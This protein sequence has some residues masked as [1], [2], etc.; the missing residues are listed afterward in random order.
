MPLLLVFPFSLDTFTD[1]AWCYMYLYT[2]RCRAEIIF[3]KLSAF[4]KRHEGEIRRKR[5]FGMRMKNR[6]ASERACKQVRVVTNGVNNK[7]F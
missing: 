7:M 2:L 4:K 3:R 5:E 1:T 6:R